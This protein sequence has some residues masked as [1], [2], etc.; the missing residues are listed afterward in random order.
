LALLILGAYHASATDWDLVWWLVTASLLVVS[1]AI[2]WLTL[3]GEVKT[4]FL[5]KLDLLWRGTLRIR[6]AK[7]T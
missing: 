5:A 1:L 2:G 6:R 3:P 4:P 7:Q